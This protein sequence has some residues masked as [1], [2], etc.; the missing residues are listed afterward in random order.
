MSNPDMEEFYSA[1]LLH[2][3]QNRNSDASITVLKH[4]TKDD[5]NRY[6]KAYSQINGILNLNVFNYAK[7]TLGNLADAMQ[8]D[9]DELSSGTHSFG[10][11][12]G[13][14]KVGVR[15]R[16]AVL[17]FCSALHFHQEHTYN[18]V[19]K[20]H[21]EGS[22]PHRQI[23]TIFNRLFEKSPEY[24]ILY[25][26]R[27]TMVHCTMETVAISATTFLSED[28][29]TKAVTL[30]AI[31]LSAIIDL[32]N[33][34]SEKYKDELREMEPRPLV[35]NLINESMPLVVDANERILRRMHPNIDES[36]SI[37]VEFDSLFEGREGQRLMTLERSTNPPP[38]LTWSHQAWASN[39]I[40]YA[41]K[42]A[43]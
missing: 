6:D 43:K 19:K 38:P 11:Q 34:I 26:T 42:H 16:N 15:M 17:A 40:E 36:C 37:I 27:N 5:Y 18:E 20:I 8:S 33:E 4:L 9:M 32:N 12:D 31:D 23:T 28:G 25:H 24:R 7:Y 1:A 14:V 13:I 21:G 29:S 35:M 30:P 22:K 39:V 10:T 2:G 41:K 3:S